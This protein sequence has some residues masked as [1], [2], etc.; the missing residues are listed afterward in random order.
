MFFF[1][2]G[3]G[4]NS[5]W[6]TLSI[7]E[8]SYSSTGS[9]QASLKVMDDYGV[10]SNNAAALSIT[11]QALTSLELSLRLERE[12]TYSE[13]EV[14]VTV[15][16]KTGTTPVGS[17]D[18]TVFAIVGGSFSPSSGAT[19]SAGSWTTTFTAPNVTNSGYVR[20]TARASKN[21]YTDG[22]DF[23]YI[24]VLAR[25][26]L[27]LTMDVDTVKSEGTA[28][29][30]VH[31]SCDL[32]PVA[33]AQVSIT[34][35]N[36]TFNVGTGVSDANGDIVFNFTAPRT[37]TQL[38]VTITATAA[39]M[40]YFEGEDETILTVKAKLLTVQI[41]S[42]AMMES[43]SDSQIT[44]LVTD[45]ETPVEGVNVTITSDGGTFLTNTGITNANGTCTFVFTAP[46]ITT[47]TAVNVTALAT[48]AGYDSVEKRATINVAALIVPVEGLAGLP[49]LTIIL[50]LIPIIA[51]V[52]VAVLIKMKVLVI[53]RGDTE[54]ED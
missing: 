28:S 42:P 9:F 4:T 36:G 30:F 5:S 12:D 17:A 41:S 6:T 21:G 25:L 3:D 37:T 38:N 50:I 46:E 48:K 47:D 33:D 22:A 24:Q 34:A 49:W 18:I 16:V 29:A 32:T 26:V 52:V 13:G 14:S 31:V 43:E 45:N 2:F 23:T 51:V 8:H 1:D 39:K 40:G 53:S 44:V 27:E 54:G 19:D 10:V 7:F 11:V 35:T 15:T 20:I